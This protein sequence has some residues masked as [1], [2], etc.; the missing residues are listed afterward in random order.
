MTKDDEAFLARLLATFKVEAQEHLA[1]MSA[2][3]VALERPA[4]EAEVPVRVET[5]FRE[6]HS[7]KGAARSVNL[8]D[9]ERLCQALE[10]VLSAVKRK[11]VGLTPAMVDTLYATFDLLGQLLAR[12]IDGK[13]LHG[14]AP[15]AAQIAAL[16]SLLQPQVEQPRTPYTPARSE[17]QPATPAPAAAPAGDT[18]RIGTAKLEL[19]LAQAEE[20]HAHKFASGQL[21]DEL[22]QLSH[23]LHEWRRRWDKRARAARATRRSLARPD[24]DTAASNRQVM[25]WLES[26]DSDELFAT[27]LADR[28]AQIERDAAQQRRVLTA[29]V[30]RLTD[31]VKQALM[32]P[33][34]T[35]FEPLPK[36]V[37]DLARDSGKDIGLV[38]R[39]AAIEVDRRILEQMKVPL[40]HLIRNAVDHGIETPDERRRLGKPARGNITIEL[41]AHEGSKVQVV[42]SDDGAGISADE[43]KAAA[44]KSGLRAP[45]LLDAM[46]E[47]QALALVFES[48]LS[49][50]PILTSLSGHG[51]GLAIVREKVER[52][53]GKLSLASTPGQG[54]RFSMLLPNTLATFRGLLVSVAER[55]F[56]LPSGSVERVGRVRR[57]QIRS[58]D[59]REAI[60]LDR[61]ALPLAHLAEVLALRPVDAAGTRAAATQ[62]VAV[63]ASGGQRMAFAVDE[64]IG[65]QE[66]LV[67]P[68]GP[69]L[70][71]VRHV[72]AAT[73]LGAGHVVP[74][75]SVEDLMRTA[76]CAAPTPPR[77]SEPAPAHRRSLLVAE[78]S[79]TSRALRKE[80]LESA[81]YRV[82][83]AA[84]GVEALTALHAA[85]FD[86]LVSDVE[87]PRMDGFDLTARV[88]ADR[89]LAELPVVLVT[90]LESR[91]DKER[92]VDVGANAYVV[93][94]GFDKSRLL[95]I[96]RTLI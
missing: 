50:S 13:P 75:L 22:Q 8:A 53:G 62:H 10:R 19:L 12:D 90:A 1:A 66:V 83:T 84:D 45:Q 17:P 24:G 35:L 58:S 89:R 30:D 6:A 52:L 64:V 49:T 27:T 88:R 95:D 72:A 40:T 68:L 42:L 2:E 56:V 46:D 82:T 77:R 54:T 7:L 11:Q 31:V 87:M 70:K 63:L 32:L 60:D 91:E 65:D 33:F 39:G 44:R 73:V 96:I 9:V 36:L 34:A 47:T 37:R 3:L 16:E 15:L 21:V 71:R 23:S 81:G 76:L 74:L 59:G 79:G 4:P 55:Q 26:V 48:G 28:L 38:T 93:K 69:P 25:Q 29:R 41:T 51:L 14:A 57:E 85:D 67:K 5:L 20:L 86:L 61:Q 92:G 80:I 18:V 43:V 78:D 94:S